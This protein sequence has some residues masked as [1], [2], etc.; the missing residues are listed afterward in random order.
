MR[1][2]FQNL[3]GN[4]IKYHRASRQQLRSDASVST[5]DWHF[6]VKDDGEGIP[7]EHQS[8]I[9]Q[10]MKRFHGAILRVLALGSRS[11]KPSWRGTGDGFGLNPQDRDT[12]Q[13]FTSPLPTEAPKLEMVAPS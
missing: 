4:A 7:L 11:A 6:S 10:A 2:L 12:D 8:A 13:R 9:F 1:Q 5:D 3:A